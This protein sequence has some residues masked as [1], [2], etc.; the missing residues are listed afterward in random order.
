[1]EFEPQTLSDIYRRFIT[2]QIA[3][4]EAGRQIVEYTRVHRIEVG[5]LDLEPMSEEERVKAGQLLDHL[6]RPIEQQFLLGKLSKENAARQI[7]SYLS[8]H[9]IWAFSFNTDTASPEE[10]KKLEQLS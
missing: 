4:D 3:I 10:R 5:C 9:S 6:L 1:M 2:G 7:A 8:P